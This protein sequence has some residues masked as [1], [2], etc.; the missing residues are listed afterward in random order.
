MLRMLSICQKLVL[1]R[2]NSLTEFKHKAVIE[3][4]INQSGS[5]E[6]LK[7]AEAIV[8]DLI[9]DWGE[10]L[11]GGDLLT[12]ERI[13]QNKSLTSS[14]LTELEKMGFLGSSRVAVFHFRQNIVL[15][16]FSKLLPNLND[17]E[18]PGTLNC[19]RALTARAREISNKVGFI[20]W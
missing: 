18:N 20:C 8:K 11:I 12:A 10:I 5:L 19:F 17:S 1:N 2:L 15:K 9:E 14:N 13:D 7:E 3:M 16:V 6:D 4:V